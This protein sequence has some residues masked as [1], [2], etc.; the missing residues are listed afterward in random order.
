[1]TTA[2]EVVTV[3]QF[4]R[5]LR[6]FHDT[7][8]ETADR[9][10]DPVHHKKLWYLGLLPARIT[11][12]V[13]RMFGVAFDYAP[14]A[15]EGLVVHQA[16]ERI[17][18]AVVTAPPELW[19]TNPAIRVEGAGCRYSYIHFVDGF[20][21]RLV[22]RDAQVAF[23]QCL[24]SAWGWTQAVYYLEVNGNNSA[25]NWTDAKAVE[26]AKELVLYAVADSHQ[27]SQR[28]L[29]IDAYIATWKQKRVLLLGA[30][31]KGGRERLRKLK[32]A[33]AL[34]GYEPT[35]VEDI[36][37]G[38]SMDVRQKVAVL[39]TMSRFVLVDDSEPSGHI[40]ELLMAHHNDWITVVL[41]SSERP[42]TYMTAGLSNTSKVV[43]E[44]QFDP[45]SPVD[46]LHSAF[47]WAE[48]V[49]AELQRNNR[50][51]FPWMS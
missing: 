34:L 4:R 13:S 22:A 11:G 51:T 39:G 21:F 7:L 9:H 27:S 8:L 28:A 36:P 30:F 20:P 16:D 24:F 37:D 38:P 29:S 43:Y 35:L 25:E 15:K 47:A 31:T 42:S 1:M 10:V 26:R 50:K 23:H 5:Y 19:H 48:Q 2:P 12:V 33:V 14:E 46:A 45:D 17:E 18:R 32:E 44:I 41:R 40:A 6:L 3:H 49:A